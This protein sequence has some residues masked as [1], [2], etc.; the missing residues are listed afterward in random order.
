[1]ISIV[2]K[3]LTDDLAQFISGIHLDKFPREV[4]HQ[5]KICFKCGF[6]KRSKGSH[7][8]HG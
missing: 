2:G 4:V 1:V 3:Q 6:L 7:I 5:T 8:R